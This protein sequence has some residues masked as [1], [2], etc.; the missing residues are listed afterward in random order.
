MIKV[1]KQKQLTVFFCFNIDVNSKGGC[2]MGLNGYGL[3]KV[4]DVEN[5]GPLMEVR[6]NLL[7]GIHAVSILKENIINCL[8]PISMECF[9]ASWK[10]Q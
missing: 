7:N 6:V 9:W 3:I 1:V 4:Y 5:W 8:N 10:R 2:G